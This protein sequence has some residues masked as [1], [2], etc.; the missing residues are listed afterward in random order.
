M[1]RRWIVLTLAVSFM[2]ACATSQSPTPEL[3]PTQARPTRTPPPPATAVPTISP[4]IL[5][6]GEPLSD[7]RGRY[8][9]ASG[10]CTA[11]HQNLEDESGSDVSI[12]SAWRSS[13]MANSARDPF[14]QASVRSEIASRPNA[15]ASIEN[16]CATCHMPMAR[17]TDRVEGG[18]A[19]IF[20][21]DLIDPDHPLH[22]LAMDGVSCTLCHQVLDEGLGFQASYNGGFEVD[23]E[24]APGERLIYGPY[25]VDEPA[26]IA[27]QAA[28]GYVPTQG[29]QLGDSELC[30]TCH[31]FFA[32]STFPIQTTYFEWFYSDARGVQTCQDCHM[33]E[34][35]GGV[36][37]ATAS[38]FPRSPF[39]EHVLVGGNAYML[40][41]LKT[42]VDELSL[43]ASAEQF[44]ITKQRT[45]DQLQN[46]SVEIEIEEIRLS[47]GRLTADLRIK[48]LAGHKFPSG[49]PSRRAWI[50]FVIEDSS[51]QIVFESGGFDA[52]GKIIYNNG[53]QDPTR[54]EPHY[55]AVV[56]PEQV[57]I[58]ESI[59][60]DAN[61][62]ITTEL[63]GAV[64]YLKDNRIMPAGQDKFG[65]VE[66]IQPSGKAVGDED[67]QGGVDEIQYAIDLRQFQGPFTV[68]IEVLYQSIS[69]TW[70]EAMRGQASDETVRFLR[71]YD[72]VPN[73][74]VVVARESIEIG[75]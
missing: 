50:R 53:D 6:V 61:G 26:V 73:I 8:F 27:M 2:A 30:G 66:S 20:G 65:A 69:P 49:F 72:A 14:W 3:E 43:T 74:P 41:L 56:Q 22:D 39:A 25:S 64:E 19:G 18:Q 68:T 42:F 7:F 29:L 21:S 32:G 51:G 10:D 46:R 57:Q 37:I 45:I 67:F 17:Y 70:T 75:G 4:V 55:L 63:M 44:E 58:Y 34:A 71:L 28:S 24:T 52:L 23:L 36:R 12:G 11:C 9:S 1:N 33:P 13:M 35:V 60:A 62:E 54:F 5:Q 38:E 16:T 59:M 15:A 31:T 47:G 40:E 48:N